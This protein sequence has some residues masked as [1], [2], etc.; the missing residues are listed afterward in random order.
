MPP[1]PTGLPAR[2][3]PMSYAPPAAGRLL[4][5]ARDGQRLAEVQRGIAFFAPEIGGARVPGMGLPALRPRLAAH[6]DRGAAD[7]DAGATDG[8]GV[9]AADRAD[10]G[11][12]DPAAGAGANDRR[13]GIRCRRLPAARWRWTISSDG[14]NGTASCAARQCASRANMRCAAAS[15]IF[16]RPAPRRRCGSISSATHWRRSAPSTP[17]RS[18][19]SPRAAYRPRSRIGDGAGAGHDRALPRAVPRAVRRRRPR[20]PAL[21]F[22]ERGRRYVGMEHW[23]PL[24][25]DKLETLFD[26]V[27]G[28]TVVLD[29]LVEEATAER[30]DQIC[31]PLRGAGAGTGSPATPAAGRPYKPLPPDRL[32][33]AKSEWNALIRQRDA[34]HLSPFAQPENPR[35]VDFGGRNG[36][37]FAAERKDENANV[38]DAVIAHA[39]DLAAAGK[40]VIVACWSDGSRDR[41][42]QVLVDHGMTRLKPVANWGE[43]TRLDGDTVALAVIGLEA[44]FETAD[45]AVIGEQD[46][47]GDRLVRPHQ[48][49]RGGELSRRRHGA[50]GRRPR[51]PHRPRHRALQRLEDD[52][53]AGR[54]AR[55]PRAALCWQR[56]R[57]PAGRE[58]RAVVPLRLRGCGR[59]A[60]Q[61]RRRRPGNRARRGSRSASAT[62]RQR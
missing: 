12:R 23:L 24:F 10:D 16:S 47:L 7:G 30:F 37:S 49:R 53:G 56:P 29:H 33:L 52:R 34:A 28:A 61:A 42:G 5:V 2:C 11:E 48:K 21:P 20:R 57:L 31:R 54:A 38:F 27:G 13:R 51:R 44:G 14:S 60:R 59:A 4:F 45:L 55:L 41:T 15:S 1:Y 50:G 43:V 19:P 46:I 62:W 18:A 35:V 6:L 32:Y 22:G 36:R 39:G 17:T 8:G 26:H 9:A 40:R 58:H 3:W 25:A